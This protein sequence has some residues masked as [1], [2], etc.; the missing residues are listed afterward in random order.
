MVSLSRKIQP[1]DLL[2]VTVWLPAVIQALR[3]VQ[4]SYCSPAQVNSPWGMPSTATR[5][6]LPSVSAVWDWMRFQPAAESGKTSQML[7]A[8]DS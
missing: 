5:L 7:S 8:S 6:V 1:Q 3:T 4:S 2:T